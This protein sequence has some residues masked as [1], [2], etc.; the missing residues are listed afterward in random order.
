MYHWTHVEKARLQPNG[1][2]PKTDYDEIAQKPSVREESNGDNHNGTVIVASKE[3]GESFATVKNQVLL[4]ETTAPTRTSNSDTETHVESNQISSHNSMHNGTLANGSVEEAQNRSDALNGHQKGDDNSQQVCDMV[5]K[6]FVEISTQTDDDT[7]AKI[8][9]KKQSEDLQ[10]CSPAP[11][12]PPPPPPPSSL[13]SI[14]IAP[15]ADAAD[16]SIDE[17]PIHAEQCPVT[18]Q[19]NN[20]QNN[21]P[22]TKLSSASSFC[23]PPPPPMNGVPGPPPLPLPTGNMWF[24]SDSKYIQIDV[25]FF[26]GNLA[27]FIGLNFLRFVL[28]VDIALRKAAKHPSKPMINLFWTRILIPKEDEDGTASEEPADHKSCKAREKLW[29]K[30]D[31]TSLDNAD[32]F[33]ELFS[34]QSTPKRPREVS[35]VSKKCVIKVLD[36]KRSQSVGIFSQSLY[37]HR[38]NPEVIQRAL[39]DCDP[40]N[41]GLDLLQQMLEHRA[42]ADELKA[43]EDAQKSAAPN[44]PLD[45]PEHFLLKFSEISCAPERIACMIFCNDFEEANAQIERKIKLIRDLCA[46]LMDDCN[47]RELF[48]IILTLGNFMNGGNRYRGQADGFGLDVLGK[49]RDVR[50]KDKKVTLLHFIVKT[51]IGKRRQDGLKPKEISYPIPDAD[52]VKSA[53]TVDFDVL[54]DLIEQLSRNL[55]G[56]PFGIFEEIDDFS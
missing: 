34:R 50:S 22:S 29:Q 43:I 20:S 1:N 13:P 32:D 3:R 6:A 10:I 5:D 9:D 48:A 54:S 46:F 45:G 28:L 21:I 27:N 42:T 7:I 44:M 31:E 4:C 39:Y 17:K 25:E 12:P 14:C 47:L 41:I 40:S 30:I 8:C 53:S 56:K 19:Q 24:K 51:F 16:K 37:R 49:L 18:P 15:A 35:K 23:P 26:V 52:D 11:P 36:H 33:T 2:G 55:K 38:I